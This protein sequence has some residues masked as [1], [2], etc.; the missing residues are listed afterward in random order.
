MNGCKTKIWIFAYTYMFFCLLFCKQEKKNTYINQINQFNPALELCIQDFTSYYKEK[1]GESNFILTAHWEEYSCEG[2]KLIF[3]SRPMNQ[4]TIRICQFD[5]FIVADSTLLLLYTG[6]NQ[7][8]KN[9]EDD[10]CNKI[11][12]MFSKGKIKDDWDEINHEPFEDAVY[13]SI[14]RGYKISGDSI[15]IIEPKYH[16]SFYLPCIPCPSKI[17]APP[18]VQFR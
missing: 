14:I 10:E 17:P 1:F 13:N 7:I 4:S 9:N 16:L 6:L 11:I 2:L 3:I 18:G 5:Q 15:S 8:K 12:S